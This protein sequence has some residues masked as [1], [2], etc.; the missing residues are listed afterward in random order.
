MLGSR[1]LSCARKT[2]QRSR[3]TA[4]PGRK[5]SNLA[6]GAREAAEEVAGVPSTRRGTIQ[7]WEAALKRID[8]VRIESGVSSAGDWEEAIRACYRTRQASRL[9]REVAGLRGAGHVPSQEALE[10]EL[11]ALAALGRGKD[12]VRAFYATECPTAPALA[13]AIRA[14]AASSSPNALL[15]QEAVAEGHGLLAHARSLSVEPSLPVIEAGLELLAAAGCPRGCADLLDRAFALR[16][17]HQH[18]ASWQG[19]LFGLGEGEEV[20]FVRQLCPYPLPVRPSRECLAHAARAADR[21][22][23]LCDPSAEARSA[24]GQFAGWLPSLL[25][26]PGTSSSASRALHADAASGL[27]SGG[28]GPGRDPDTLACVAASMQA[29][30]RGGDP[31]AVLALASQWRL[32]P[33]LGGGHWEGAGR[34]EEK[35]EGEE[36]EVLGLIWGTPPPA[37]SVPAAGGAAPLSAD[38]AKGVTAG[39]AWAQALRG[40]VEAGG[41][42]QDL[43]VLE[44]ESCRHEGATAVA[45]AL[46][47]LSRVQAASDAAP[48]SAVAAQAACETAASGWL[49]PAVATALPPCAAAV[50]GTR[51][52]AA[53]LHALVGG[54]EG[55]YALGHDPE[56][57]A[58]L[59]EAAVRAVEGDDSKAADVRHRALGCLQVAEA[60][61][62][63]PLA[64]GGSEPWVRLHAAAATA[65]SRMREPRR[66][67]RWLKDAVAGPK[68]EGRRRRGRGRGQGRAGGAA[69]RKGS[70]PPSTAPAL[71]AAA[72]EAIAAC[73]C[74][75][76]AAC[77]AELARVVRRLHLMGPGTQCALVAS[78]ALSGAADE[79]EG[80]LEEL[81]ASVGGRAGQS[82][83]LP[84]PGTGPVTGGRVS[85][86]EARALVLH[87]AALDASSAGEAAAAVRCA[88]TWAVH[89][90]AAAIQ[91]PRRVTYAAAQPTDTRRRPRDGDRSPQFPV[92]TAAGEELGE[93][94]PG[95][96]WERVERVQ[97]LLQR[98]ESRGAAT[99]PAFRAAAEALGRLRA[100]D[101]AAR[102]LHELRRGSRGKGLW[103]LP[104]SGAHSLEGL[105]AEGD[106]LALGAQSGTLQAA[107]PP[108]TPRGATAA[109]EVVVACA[110]A[111]LQGGRPPLSLATLEVLEEGAWNAAPVQGGHSFTID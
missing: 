23:S 54:H 55:R 65:A 35:E 28:T 13:H 74:V 9:V 4:L 27:P 107:A 58:R 50:G 85:P 73:A 71:R 103:P 56:V 105:W 77:A 47:A 48:S 1:T 17:R 53:V 14:V 22:L 111:A 24:V 70:L 86:D 33:A 60:A 44:R 90:H 29:L 84:D 45:A 92:V 93:E 42:D 67:L 104:S 61:L 32:L 12:A 34:A 52:V 26:Q 69:A 72:H 20:E 78:L 25:S 64:V 19:T 37:P 5:C 68:A 41:A 8:E 88:A 101:Q 81:W 79:A 87:A 91:A 51:G 83:A 76:D 2:A 98:L 10:A 96:R 16:L 94:G 106:A 7:E 110:W 82:L 99:L 21:F 3:S 102:L 18:T 109:T 63:G 75:R 30:S 31:T 36:E 59:T 80:A 62:A 40:A 39:D 43:A 108:A 57:G 38:A 95:Q 89:A 11:Y 49:D 15:G 6:H 66:A 97:A 100:P 46:E